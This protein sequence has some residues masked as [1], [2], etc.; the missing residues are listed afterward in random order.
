MAEIT[1]LENRLT[2][3]RSVCSGI[4]RGALPGTLL[5]VRIELY[6]GVA[7]AE[8]VPHPGAVDIMAFI[9]YNLDGWKGAPFRRAFFVLPAKKTR[10]R[11]QG[12]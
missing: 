3:R 11:M 12:V 9:V 5:T 1:L 7:Q 2:V 8:A 10:R 6:R 4:R